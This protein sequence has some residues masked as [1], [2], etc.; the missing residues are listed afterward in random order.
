MVNGIPGQDQPAISSSHNEIGNLFVVGHEHEGE[1]GHK[2]EPFYIFHLSTRPL[3]IG[4]WQLKVVLDDG[5][6]HTVVISFK[7][8]R[9]DEKNTERDD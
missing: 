6:I 2:N 5:T 8:G 9:E 7:S 3:T 4:T 1:Y